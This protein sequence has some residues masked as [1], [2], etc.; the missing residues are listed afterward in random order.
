MSWTYTGDPTS[1]AKD[2]VRFLIGDTDQHDPLLDDQEILYMLGQYNNAPLNAAI[3][4]CEQIAA[5]FSRRV[6]ES[7]GQVR[8]DFA[9]ASKAYRDM[10]MDLRRRMAIEGV[11]PFAGGISKSQKVSENQDKD[12]VKPNFSE[13]MQENEQIS[14]WTSTIQ[15]DYLRQGV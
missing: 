8:M 1:S 14:P 6:N 15:D 12:R 3:R 7:V 11:K 10:A 13:H 5:K 4:C 9:Q 2:S